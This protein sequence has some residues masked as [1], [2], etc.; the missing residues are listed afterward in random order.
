MTHGECLPP[1]CQGARPGSVGQ[2]I[3]RKQGANDRSTQGKHALNGGG[4]RQVKPGGLPSEFDDSGH[5]LP[6]VLKVRYYLRSIWVRCRW[7][8][9]GTRI[10]LIRPFMAVQAQGFDRV[11]SA[12]TQ[13]GSRTQL[14]RKTI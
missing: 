9:M 10:Q 12:R 13:T 4:R 2:R 8:V 7:P 6:P 3:T 14:M 5:Q 11:D 1:S